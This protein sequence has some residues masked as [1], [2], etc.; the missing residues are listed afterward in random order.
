MKLLQTIEK[1]E[2]YLIAQMKAALPAHLDP[3]RLLRIARSEIAA[4]PKLQAVDPSSFLNALIRAASLGLEP[5]LL[6]QCYLI[7]YGK[8][9][10]LIVGYRGMLDLVR[11]SGEVRRFGAHVVHSGDEFNYALGLDERLVHKPALTERGEPTHV[12]AYCEFV[13]GDYQYDVMD[14]LEIEAIRSRSKARG[15]PWASSWAEMVKK[16]VLRRLCKYLPLT[17]EAQE[18]LAVDSGYESGVVPPPIIDIP[19]DPVDKNAGA[20]KILE[21]TKGESDEQ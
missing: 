7:P 19:A 6:Q 10:Q 20:K 21:L 18:G 13:G 15:G 9:C 17:V 16:T 2:T 14:L 8:E 12:Y 1:R 11:R 4:N 5:G 3:K